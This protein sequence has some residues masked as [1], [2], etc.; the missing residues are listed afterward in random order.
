M[1]DKDKAVEFLLEKGALQHLA[2][3]EGKDACDYA[4]ASGLAEKLPQF[5]NCSLK[6]KKDEQEKIKRMRGEFGAS[7]GG[8][9]RSKGASFKNARSNLNNSRE[10]FDVNSRQ[11]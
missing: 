9:S 4:K 1:K 2:D 10:E 3:D 8:A 6:K 5:M 11:S 7:F